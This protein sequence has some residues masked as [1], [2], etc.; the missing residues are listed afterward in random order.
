MDPTRTLD[1]SSPQ[2]RA[3]VDARALGTTARVV[4]VLRVL[5]EGPDEISVAGVASALQLP[6]ATAHRLLTLLK[7]QGMVDHDPDSRRYSVGPEFFRMASLV[8]SRISVEAL[9]HPVMKRLVGESGETTLLAL[10]RPHDHLMTFAASERADHALGYTVEMQR[11]LNIIWGASG[12]AILAALP[13]DR[14]D[15]VL[16]VV[17]EEASPMTG[18][19]LSA[20]EVKEDL[21]R[22]RE[23]GYAC[24]LSQR[25]P[26]A[27]SVAAAF[28]TASG[29]PAGSIAVTLPEMRREPDTEERLVG[30]VTSAAH[31]I[32]RLLGDGGERRSVGVE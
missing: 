31:D 12:R 3:T 28:R 1:G 10:Y 22:I 13:D 26:H 2:Q 29:D 5:A 32:G 11:P 7:E 8:S 9:A 21:A 15:I 14:V 23:R 6:R 19:V 18:E 24:S 25:I 4:E 17:G 30:P 20:G 27:Y 16:K